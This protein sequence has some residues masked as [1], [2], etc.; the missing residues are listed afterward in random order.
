M[1]KRVL[2]RCTREPL[3]CLAATLFTAILAVIL[4]FL[5]K[6][7]EE[8]MQ[9][10]TNTYYN[11]P[12]TFEVCWLDG[13]RL[14][15]ST[16]AS[17]HF[18]DLMPGLFL[19][20]GR[21]QSRFSDLIDKVHIRMAHARGKWWEKEEDKYVDVEAGEQSLSNSE[22]VVGITSPEAACD[23]PSE[24]AEQIRWY[25]GYDESVL[26]TNKLV[27]I[28]SEDFEGPEELEITFD[29]SGR[30]EYTCTLKVVGRY[31][32]GSSPDNGYPY[33]YCPYLVMEHIYSRLNRPY[34]LERVSGQLANND[35]L[36][37]FKEAAA[38]W[39]AT[40]NA[41]GTSTPW[42][43][44][45]GYESYPLAIDI[46][47]SQLA[48]LMEEMEKSVTINRI[49]STLVFILSAGAGFLTGFLVIRSRKREIGLMRTLGAS[50]AAVCLEL[51][52]EQ[53]LCVMLGIAVGGSYALWA[54]RKQ[55]CIF[56]GVYLAG[57]SVALF[58]FTRANLLATMKE[59]E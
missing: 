35:D 30:F 17:G 18:A 5:H 14:Y 33:I 22:L 25:D 37:Q 40:P 1:I 7:Q 55:L 50:N 36:E 21:Y 49:A 6:A 28:V 4:C 51:A 47:D 13:S 52:L 19:G 46:D 54:P 26:R 20:N 2:R 38:E 45:F 39:F 16:P 29:E 10:L 59:D 11:T 56:A 34:E 31:A 57:L 43:N 15:D 58:V 42:D 3:T 53:I 41:L 44:V 12:I 24:F 32:A 9:D 48:G 8:E 23:Y 27:C